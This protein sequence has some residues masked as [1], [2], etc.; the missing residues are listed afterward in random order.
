MTSH[1]LKLDWGTSKDGSWS[2]LFALDAEDPQ[3]K[4]LEG[5]Y[6]LWHGGSQPGMVRVGQGEIKDRIGFLRNDPAV[7]KFR[8]HGLFL[9]WAKVDRLQREGVERFLNERLQPKLNANGPVPKS[10]AIAVNLP[11][12]AEPEAQAPAP[13]PSAQAAAPAS[14]PEAAPAIQIRKSAGAEAPA[15]PAAPAQ[16]AV[17]AVQVEAPKAPQLQKKFEELLA[18]DQ[19]KTSRG[20]FGGGEVP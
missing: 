6:V 18:P 9:T 14:A 5:V 8:E 7:L 3:F 11:G 20:F 2:D 4:G 1:N 16:P 12:H 10:P 13:A 17:A 15:A 19:K